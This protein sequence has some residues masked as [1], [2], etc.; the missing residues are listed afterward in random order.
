MIRYLNEIPASTWENATFHTYPATIRDMANHLSGDQAARVASLVCHLASKLDWSKIA[1]RNDSPTLLAF[2]RLYLSAVVIHGSDG[3]GQSAREFARH[4]SWSHIDE[5]ELM[6]EF[7]GD[8][9]V[10]LLKGML[11]LL[12]HN[13]Y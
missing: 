4:A 6:R 8:V 1:G 2:L 11:E 12:T 9:F 5:D 3:P 10:R 7:N 13:F